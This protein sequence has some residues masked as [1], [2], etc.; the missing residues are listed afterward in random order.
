[1]IAQGKTHF[2]LVYIDIYIRM[3]ERTDRIF[4]Q[5]GSRRWGESTDDDDDEKH[6]ASFIRDQMQQTRWWRRSGSETFCASSKDIQCFLGGMPV[7]SPKRCSNVPSREH[8][9]NDPA[10][11]RCGEKQ[12]V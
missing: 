7:R 1:M 11:I 9:L 4:H 12:R 3:R 10:E 8:V 2:R 5:R 6:G